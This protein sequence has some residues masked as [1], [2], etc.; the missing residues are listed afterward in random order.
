MTTDAQQPEPW[1]PYQHVSCSDG[2]SVH[3]DWPCDRWFDWHDTAIA[4]VATLATLDALTGKMINYFENEADGYL[5]GL[6][7]F[8]D[9]DAISPKRV[10]QWIQYLRRTATLAFISLAE[11]LAS[12][13]V[14][15]ARKREII[16]SLRRTAQEQQ[17]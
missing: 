12:Q 16:E 13:S 5:R 11:E 10:M 7:L 15:D 1:C 6:P 17:R 8:S 2:G 3:C 9:V 4:R 14:S